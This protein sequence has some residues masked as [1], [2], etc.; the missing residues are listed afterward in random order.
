MPIDRWVIKDDHGRNGHIGSFSSLA[1]ETRGP[2]E[3][4]ALLEIAED[5]YSA[6]K[7]GFHK[8]CRRDIAPPLR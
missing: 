2:K 8:C 5:P 6:R 3:L 7:A 1:A 4:A